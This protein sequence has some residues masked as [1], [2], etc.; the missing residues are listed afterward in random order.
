[1]I[2]DSY[3]DFLSKDRRYAVFGVSRLKK[4]FGNYILE[5]L[6]RSGYQAVGINPSASGQP[7]I[8]SSIDA[9]PL[10]PNAAII[11]V[12]RKNTQMA[13]KEC[14]KFGINDIWLQ[15]GTTRKNEL[16]SID[17]PEGNFWAGR[18]ILLYLESARFPH[19]IHRGLLSIMGR[20]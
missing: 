17:R 19:N 8:Y 4:K 6:Q 13:L 14:Q 20:H 1:M 12:A 18:C 16:D 11:A 15:P 2:L 5:S 9:S 3:G 10:A 7:N